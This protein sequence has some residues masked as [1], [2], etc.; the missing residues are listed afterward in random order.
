MLP[1]KNYFS[2]KS[3]DSVFYLL[4][5]SAIGY[6]LYPRAIRGTAGTLLEIDEFGSIL[7]YNSVGKDLVQ[8]KLSF[9][10]AACEEEKM[11]WVNNINLP[12]FYSDLHHYVSHG[13]VASIR[14]Q[15]EVMSR[16]IY[17]YFSQA[18]RP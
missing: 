18:Y 11:W 6:N 15:D 16:L 13:G 12:L 1:I 14:M 9:S 7:R 2:L 4:A 3:C 10:T 17:E 8:Y 5:S